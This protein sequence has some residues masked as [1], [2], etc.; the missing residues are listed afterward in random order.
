MFGKKYTCVS[1]YIR[2]EKKLF[3]IER[4]NGYTFIRFEH[5]LYL[6]DDLG[7]KTRGA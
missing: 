7:G 1:C 3:F 4:A 6:W 5:R 2:N